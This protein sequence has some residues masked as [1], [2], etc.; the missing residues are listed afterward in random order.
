MYL[1][2]LLLIFPVATPFAPY[3]TRKTNLE[4]KH[5][6]RNKFVP[7]EL[8]CICID[9]AYVTSC[10]AYHFV[11]ARHAQPHIAEEPTFTPRDGSPTIHV[12]IRVEGERGMWEDKSK[13][14]VTYEYDVVECGDF[15]EDKGCW[16]R[17][18]PDEIKKANPDFVPT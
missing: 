9:C 8:H 10:K 7:T 1:C 12:N 5:C 6:T 13:G 4:A 11:E 18:M 14:E 15:K 3:Y 2:L 17:N 16:V